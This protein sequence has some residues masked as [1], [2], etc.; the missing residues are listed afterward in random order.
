MLS[1][2][3]ESSTEVWDTFLR[4]LMEPSLLKQFT[5]RCEKNHINTI[6]KFTVNSQ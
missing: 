2:G 3:E 5:I 1:L 4:Q 6:R